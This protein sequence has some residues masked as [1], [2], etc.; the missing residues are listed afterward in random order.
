MKKFFIPV[1]IAAVAA[2]SCGKAKFVN[3]LDYVDPLI[4]TCSNQD[5]NLWGEPPADPHAAARCTPGALVPFGMVNVGPVTDYHANHASGYNAHDTTTVGFGFMRMSG[6][7]W[8]GEF[9]NLL[10][11]PTTGPLNTCYGLY[12]GEFP[13]YASRFDPYSAIATPG[14]Y[15]VYLDDYGVKAECTATEHCGALRFTFP[16]SELSRIQSDLAFRITGS[17]DFQEIT[18]VDDYSFEG[19]MKYTPHTGG[20][21]NGSAQIYYDLYFFAQLSRPLGEYGFWKAAVPES[22]ERKDENVNTVEYMQLLA[23]AEII[24]GV[25]SASGT[26]IGFFT[27]FPTSEGE[28]VEMKV[29]FSFV[30]ADGARKNFAAEA[31]NLTFDEMHAEAEALWGDA[32]GKV[33][34]AG[35][36]ED[37]KKCFYTALYHAMVDP[38]TM[39][40]A[41]G[42]FWGGDGGTYDAIGYTRRTLFSGWDVFRSEFPLLTIV[43]PTV[44]NDLIRSQIAL[45]DETEKRYFNRWE[46]LNS[47]TKCMLG[48][49]TVSVL[50]DAYMKGIDDYDVAKAYVYAKNSSDEVWNTGIY[51]NESVLISTVLEVAYTDWCTE[52]MARKIGTVDDVVEFHERSLKYKDYF[53]EDARWFIPKTEDGQWRDTTA[54]W[55]KQ[56]FFGACES[57]LQQQGWF[58]PHDFG[59]FTEMLGGREV[60]AEMLDTLFEKTSWTFGYE[61]YYF[62]SNEPVHWVPFL[63]NQLGQPWKTQKWTRYI[64]DHYYFADVEGMVGNDDEGQ[65][66]AWYALCAAGIHQSCPGNGRVEILSPVFEKVE[67]DLD[68]SWYKGKKFTIVAHNASPENIYVQK[69][70]LNGKRLQ[71]CWFDFSAI[72][73]GGRLELWMGPNPDSPFNKG[74]N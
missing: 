17:S 11:M 54:N 51:S 65:M 48:N 42:R 35:G 37:Q 7:G 15:S 71:D 4:A 5:T 30:D 13:G 44:V 3:P 64:L 28:Q 12:T 32:L 66:S 56:V 1:A 33:K 74:G 49:P 40:D 8:S 21:G 43:N 36:T 22:M 41:D 70:K 19:H 20:W 31:E 45:A 24:R 26:C 67:F 73:G 61:D 23:D 2:V 62:H 57:N 16:E 25:D 39:T 14:Y 29:G 68:Q 50:A 27:E 47:Y 6:T 55:R 46:L 63:Y 53:N 10:T 58:V 38:R 60:A 9:G 72:S 34:V 69:A 18:I 59:P 52:Q